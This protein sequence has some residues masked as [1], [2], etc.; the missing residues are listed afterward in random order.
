MG[1]SGSYSYVYSRAGERGSAGPASSYPIL[2]AETSLDLCPEWQQ[3]LEENK[4]EPETLSAFVKATRQARMED[5]LYRQPGN[6]VLGSE[7]DL[8]DIPR[9]FS[10]STTVLGIPTTGRFTLVHRVVPQD[11]IAADRAARA[12]GARIRPSLLANEDGHL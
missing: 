8:R 1:A 3:W 4:F 7:E 5:R 11:V 10:C 12:D 2:R 9:E 6:Y